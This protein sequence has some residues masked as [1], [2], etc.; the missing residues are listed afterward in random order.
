MEKNVR[1]YPT[2][3][4]AEEAGFRPCLRCRPECSP[5]TPVWAGTKNTVSRALQLIGE[6]GLE[7]GGVE[8]LASHLGIGSRHLRRLFLRHLGAT[9]S[10]VAQTRRLHFTKKLID[11]TRLP[12]TQIALAAGFGSVRR[13][14]AAI[15]RVYHRT[16]SQIRKLARRKDAQ[17]ENQYVFQLS[18]RPPYD[19]KRMLDFLASWATPG[20]E[21]IAD[22]TYRRT[23][24]VKKWHGYLEVSRGEGQNALSVRVQIE[25]PRALFYV[26]ERVR[27]IFDLDADWPTISKILGADG[28]LTG[29]IKSGPGLRVPGCW[30]GFEFAVRALLAEKTSPENAT[31]LAAQLVSGL[32]QPVGFGNGLTHVFPT[33]EVL[34][35]ANLQALSVPAVPAHAIRELAQAVCSG[36]V[37]FETVVD[38]DSLLANL[39]AIPG[40]GKRALQYVSLR[41]L[42]EPDAFP[43]LDPKLASAMQAANWQELEERSHAWRPWRAYAAMYLWS[44]SQEAQRG[45]QGTIEFAK[46]RK[47][48]RTLDDRQRKS[49]VVRRAS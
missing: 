21:K 37:S 38:R 48:A 22:D 46:K 40:F 29:R 30:S 33:P 15:R 1:Y 13:F 34:R 24:S 10:A 11:E 42:R 35:D 27:A 19:W 17:P 8:A 25:D 14:N 16:P 41:S 12:M 3:A 39:A 47:G 7:D 6:T 31:A 44:F 43:S 18:F 23:I 45:R 5:G 20:V 26:I 32:G 49:A 9:P 2:A 28:T 4:A 36:R